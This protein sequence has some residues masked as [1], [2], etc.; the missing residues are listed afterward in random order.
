MTAT[1]DIVTSDKQ[2]V[3]LVPNAALRFKPQAPA[4]SPA[5]AQSGITGVLPMGPRRSGTGDRTATLGRGAVQQVHVL[6]E[7]GAPRAIQ[8]T[9]GDT[10]GFRTEVLSGD[11]K[12]GMKVITSQLSGGSGG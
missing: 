6:G 5:A 10:D 8:I 9:T 11:L 12:A 1:A 2:D 3:L 4:G 7:D